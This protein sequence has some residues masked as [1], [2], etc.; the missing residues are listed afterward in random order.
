DEREPDTP[1]GSQYRPEID[2]AD[3][4]EQH[5]VDGSV[6]HLSPKLHVYPVSAHCCIVR[7][8]HLV[9]VDDRV[10]C[11]VVALRD[12]GRARFQ[13]EIHRRLAPWDNDWNHDAALLGE[14]ANEVDLAMDAQRIE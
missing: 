2:A 1:L 12:Y 11:A 8:R 14:A 13:V 10:R 9:Q 4:D 3:R 7:S 5:E 6:R